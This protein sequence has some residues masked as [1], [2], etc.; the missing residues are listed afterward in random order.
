MVV[1][2]YNLS[3]WEV[4]ARGIRSSGPTSAAQVRRQPVLPETVSKIGLGKE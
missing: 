3:P 1:Y 2:A 4:D